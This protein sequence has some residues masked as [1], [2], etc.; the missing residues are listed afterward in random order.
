MKLLNKTG[1][2]T[3]FGGC[4]IVALTSNFDYLGEI[5]AV[6]WSPGLNTP[7]QGSLY[8]T[9]FDYPSTIEFIENPGNIHVEIHLL[10]EY[11]QPH[12]AQILNIVIEDKIL[13]KEKAV[14]F[15]A[16]QL[17]G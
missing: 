7:Y 14:R 3:H 2:I 11:G 5:G 6:T 12:I 13:T 16:Q 15:V 1:T 9:H 8:F 17:I 4:D 10:D